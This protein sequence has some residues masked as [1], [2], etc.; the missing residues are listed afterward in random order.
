MAK[1]MHG[2]NHGKALPELINKTP[3]DIRSAITAIE[4]S[5]LPAS[6][7]QFVIS[8]VRLAVWFSSTLLEK[9]ISLS[10]LRKLIFGPGKS[11]ASK[12]QSNENLSNLS[13]I[14][15]TTIDEENSSS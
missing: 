4:N 9:Q 8:C 2:M 14:E 6:T 7:Q 1:S 10:N 12:P 3:E 11:K 13:D 15:K 5:N